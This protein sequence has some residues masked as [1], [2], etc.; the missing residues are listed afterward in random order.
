MTTIYTRSKKC[1]NCGT[2][3]DIT[4]LG[5]TNAFGAMDL[6]TRP[7]EMQR[8]TMRYWLQ[9]CTKCGLSVSDLSKVENETLKY[10]KSDEF[11][12]KHASENF[13]S[14][15]ERFWTAHLLSLKSEDTREAAGNI[16]HAA[17]ASDDS[18]DTHSS[19]RAREIFI[20]TLE[21]TGNDPSFLTPSEP[22]AGY[23]MLSDINRRISRFDEAK[24]LA[25]HVVEN[26]EGF[27][28]EIGQF[29]IDLC[30][31]RDSGCYNVQGQKVA[32]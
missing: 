9:S 29:V 20:E 8:S 22:L 30:E 31:K 15:A 27:I 32:F 7:P 19:T 5:S 13:K 17:W 3:N 14:L 11:K 6:D 2:I 10:F 16:L 24:R 28:Q 4:Q 23:L 25:Q 1:P 26:G 21:E 18:K 12:Q